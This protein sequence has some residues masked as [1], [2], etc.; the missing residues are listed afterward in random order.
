MNF[1]YAFPHNKMT[2]IYNGYS[3]QK[4]NIDENNN[5]DSFKKQFGFLNDDH[6]ILFVGRIQ[7]GKGIEKLIEAFKQLTNDYENLQ[8]ILVGKGELEPFMEQVQDNFGRVSFTG[9]LTA[10]QVKQLYQI[11]NIGV[12][13]SE[14]EQCSYVALEM[15]QHGLPIVCSDAPGLKELFINEENSLIAPLQARTNGL[16]GLEITSQG[17]YKAIKRLLTD[18]VLARKL[19]QNVYNNWQNHYTAAHM[20]QA[21][22]QV[23]QQLLSTDIQ[24]PKLLDIQIFKHETI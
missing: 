20:G 6:I 9:K 2:V 7:E 4:G 19:S 16:L 8:L 22:M 18:R 21:T 10:E 13:P 24:I 15:M 14:F 1:H 17:L 11:A 5:K 23:Y 12:I 3:N